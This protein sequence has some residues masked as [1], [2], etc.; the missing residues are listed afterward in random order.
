MSEFGGKNLWRKGHYFLPTVNPN[1]NTRFLVKTEDRRSK[2][3][4]LIAPYHHHIHTQR[5][6]HTHFFLLI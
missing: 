6:T 5:D 4:L 1:V 2:V 3:R